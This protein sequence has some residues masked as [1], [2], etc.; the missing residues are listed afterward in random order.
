MR[1]H[2]QICSKLLRSALALLTVATLAATSHAAVQ[3][4]ITSAV[5]TN[6]RVALARTVAP[7]AARAQDLGL[8][9]SSL[10]LENM[11]MRFSMTDTQQA[12]LSKLLVDQQNSSSPLY[13]QWL[14]PQQFGAQ[15][16]LSA[17]DLSTVSSWLAAQGFTI[18]TT[19][20]SS[21]FIA[22]SG[23]VAQAQQAFGTS[24][25]SVSLD[26]EQHIANL[27]EPTLPAALAGVVDMVSGLDDFKL[28]PRS[29]VRSVTLANVSPIGS[30]PRDTVNTTAGLEHFIAPGDFATIY[31]LNPLFT[32]SINGTGISIAVMGQVD[33]SLTDI[34]AFRTA[35]GLSANV[36]VIK[37]YGTDPGTPTGTCLGSNPP[38]SCTVTG[39]DL[40]ESELDVEWAGA[41]APSASI[42]FV[43]STDVIGT[44]LVNAIDNNIAPIMTVSYGGCEVQDFSATAI[45]T[46]NTSFQQANA[47]GITIVGPAGDAGAT[48]CDF[49]VAT[50]KDGLAVD[51]PASSPNVT[52]VGGTEFS[53]G[54]D[55]ATPNGTYWNNTTTSVSSALS[56]IPETVWND[57]AAS[58]AAA[59]TTATLSSGGGGVSVIF[60]KPTWQT[61][62]GVPADSHRDVPDLAFNASADHDPYLVCAEGSCLNGT[63]FG[64]GGAF[65]A[66]GGT[67]VSTPSFAGILALLEQKLGGRIGN[68][69]PY[70][71]ALANGASASTIFHDVTTGNNKQPCTTNS[72]SCPAGAS[73]IGYSAG[74]GYDQASGWGSV[75]ASKFVNTFPTVVTTLPSASTVTL[76]SSAATPALNQSVTFTATIAHTSGTATPS[77]TVSFTVDSGTANPVTL[78]AGVAT[79][80]ATFTTNGT[81][82]IAAVYSGDTNYYGSSG[83]VNVVA[84]TV[85]T[86]TISLSAAPST[87]TVASS[88]S[89]SSVITVT[90]AGGYAGTVNLAA[91]ANTLNGS[92]AFTSNGANVTSLTVPAGGT[93]TATFT[94]NTITAASKTGGGL[95]T[96]TGVSSLVLGGGITLAGLF[97]LGFGNR[98]QRGWSSLLSLIA[99]AGLIASAGCSSSSST[100]TTTT[101]S[102]TGT[103]TITITGTDSLTSA[104]TANTALTVTIQ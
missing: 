75:D 4:R 55:T 79:F 86:G 53:E 49:D 80:A 41:T 22:F 67:S 102:G 85:P 60:A 43:N 54:A 29:R 11:T 58:I 21:T 24:I 18:T 23:T 31:D 1:S 28:R 20:K 19:A 34:A 2:L 96:A 6:N 71:Y 27:T 7:R 93:A 16:G 100:T 91:V 32:S 82:T 101:S 92:Y 64:T 66:F 52:G 74:V 94:V 39:G 44:S 5:Q 70:I 78:N 8:A 51:F 47:Q 33:I 25:H 65:N 59:P 10:K 98:R 17:A 73:P 76:T 61:G 103:Y 15:F 48:D 38:T 88:G 26:G 50:A 56:Y 99:L 62:T 40:E 87:F 95:K 35:S 46:L 104:I 81:H 13:H 90:S 36:P 97:F 42:I 12:A 63:Y 14:T 37:T 3:N 9:P 83:S 72:T 77:G 57:T 45:G 84:G 30:R 68:A 89:I 69:N